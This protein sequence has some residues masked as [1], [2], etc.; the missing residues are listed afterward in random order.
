MVDKKTSSALNHLSSGTPQSGGSWEQTALQK[1]HKTETVYRPFK[2]G[3]IK[4]NAS[5]KKVIGFAKSTIH[6]V[7]T[8]LNNIDPNGIKNMSCQV[9]DRTIQPKQKI[10]PWRF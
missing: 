6:V 4:L 5:M 1:I 10:N 8:A 2:C 9:C 3:I 7:V